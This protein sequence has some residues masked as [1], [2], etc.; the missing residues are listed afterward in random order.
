M[1]K[2]G[3]RPI[4]G[5][6]GGCCESGPREAL[7]AGRTDQAVRVPTPAPQVGMA[8]IT[9]SRN[10]ISDR[11]PVASFIVRVPSDRCFEVA[12][13]TDPRLFAADQVSLRRSENFFSTRLGGLMRAPAGEA[14]VLIP[15]QQL[16]RF[17]GSRRL[18]YVLGSYRDPRG[19]GAEFTTIPEAVDQ[20]PYIQLSPDFTGRGLLSGRAS[21]RWGGPSGQLTWGGDQRA[22]PRADVYDDGHDPTLWSRDASTRAVEHQGPDRRADVFAE[23]PPPGAFDVEDHPAP[24]AHDPD[25]YGRRSRGV[26]PEGAEDGRGLSRG[27]VWGRRAAR[28]AAEEAEPAGFED[29]T[30]ALKAGY[31]RSVSVGS[32]R[33]AAPSPSAGSA[34]GGHEPPGL[35]EPPHDPRS[36]VFGGPVHTPPTPAPTPSTPRQPRP[37]PDG[38]ATYGRREGARGGVPFDTRER[39][40]VLAPVLRARGGVDAYAVAAV[41]PGRGLRWG[42][43]G[44]S[45]EDGG[46]AE[47]L[48]AAFGREG[49][50]GYRPVAEAEQAIGVDEA[51]QLRAWADTASRSPDRGHDPVCGRPLSDPAWVERLRR[52]GGL[53]RPAPLGL[54]LPSAD[55][56]FKAA[57]NEVAVR[58]IFGELV[59]AAAR[60]G[61]RTDRALAILL[62]RA[63]DH[64]VP[65]AER[66]YAATVGQSELRE[67]LGGHSGPTVASLLAD[68][69]LL[70]DTLYDLGEG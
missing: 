20:L 1:E 47:V 60:L 25:G 54:G 18:Y 19:Q 29:A 4:G 46:L 16:G 10:V 17:A 56:P 26:E 31:G 6:Y 35:E 64:G 21:D 50:N 15:P 9:P 30:A 8:S 58:R 69:E 61:A 59:P 43:A 55:D 51:R 32:P 63:L 70:H 62:D 7:G 24:G 27:V 2:Q 42:F 37:D 65:A 49:V 67:R 5:W 52:L 57:Q 34:Y 53:H 28:P 23:P 44:F 33:P 39:V 40:R 11:F 3:P 41:E 22:A 66:W 48:T 13:A 45:Q 36:G 68:R 14:T 38:Y 12:C